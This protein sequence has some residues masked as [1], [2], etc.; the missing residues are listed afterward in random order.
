MPGGYAEALAMVA[1]GLGYLGA[2]AAGG[3][4]AEPVPGEV[5][6]GLEAAGAR[7]AAAQ[8]AVLSRFDAAGGHDADE[9]QNSSSWLRDMAGM[10]GPAAR[11]QVK[12]M[13]SLRSR[14]RLAGAM[15][16]GR[17]SE[18]YADRIITW[19]KPLPADLLGTTDALIL[20][21]LDA[22]KDAE[23]AAC[24]ALIV[25]LVTAAPDWPVITEMIFLVLDALGRHGIR[26]AG[27]PDG[28]GGDDAG[29]DAG[30][31]ERPPLPLP[32]E[33]WQQLLYALGKLAIRFV[34][35]PGALASVLRT[36]LAPARSTPAA[37]RSTSATPTT[38]RRRSAGRSSRGPGTASGPAAATGPRPPATCTISGTRRTADRPASP[39]AACSAASTTTCASTGGDGRPGSRPTGP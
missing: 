24:D 21:V 7:H 10:T 33:A 29:P 4:L 11:R 3:Q 15:A 25:P 22:G 12:Q 13:R 31:G 16:E 8:S 18:S 34:S 2:A 14:P 37:S 38:S 6:L 32:P 36:G 17:L 26:A 23:V 9:Y 19:T 39:T 28:E 35:G 30:A 5:L 20:S 27:R 1:S